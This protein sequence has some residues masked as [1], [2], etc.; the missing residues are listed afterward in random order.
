M[1][2]D[3]YDMRL[4]GNLRFFMQ[5]GLTNARLVLCICSEEYVWKADL[6]IGGTGFE[7]LII[8]QPLL[9]DANSEH[10]ICIIR[11]NEYDNKV[12]YI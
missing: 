7:S 6:G 1:I 12:I 10:I 5:N 9:E 2:F 8:I 11:N 3:Q 4:G